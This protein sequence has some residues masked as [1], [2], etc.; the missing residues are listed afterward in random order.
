MNLKRIITL[1][2]GLTVFLSLAAE[3]NFQNKQE[4]LE[5]EFTADK[6]NSQYLNTT[7]AYPAA[8]IK[9]EITDFSAGK[10]V[11]QGDLELQLEK[12]TTS[13]VFREL[14]AHKI[15]LNLE[16]LDLDY[17]KLKISASKQAELP[18]TI[19]PAFQPLY[20]KVVENYQ[21]SYLR[22]LPSAFPKM[23]IITYDFLTEYLE[24]F[25]AWKEAKGIEVQVATIEEIGSSTENI[26]SFL[27][28]QYADWQPDYVILTGD[29][30]DAYQIPSYYITFLGETDVTDLPYCLLQGEDYW[31][32]ML[33]GR[34]S[35]DSPMELMTI[36][37]KILSYEKNP[38]TEE[39]WLESALLIA[40]NYSN[41]PPTPTTPVKVTKWLRDKM[42]DYGYQNI[43]E[44][45]YPGTYPGTDEIIASIDAGVG[46]V[47]YRG[48]GD[49]NGWHYP[50][51][52]R[53]NIEELNNGE[54][55]PV[56]TSIVCNTGDFA[57]SVDPCFGEL[58]L[59]TGWPTLTKGAVA[60][61][62]PSDL[63][64]STKYNNAVFAGF[65]HGLLTENIHGFASAVQ[66]GKI[67]LF[68]NYPHHQGQGDYVEFYFHVYNM[69][70]DP[71]LQMWTKTPET[72]NA[73][74]PSQIN[75]G[76]N[77]L[78]IDLPDL[79]GAIVTAMKDG[80]II[81]KEIVENGQAV[82]FFQLEITGDMQITIT[83]ANYL[84]LIENIAVISNNQDL[85][86]SSY[87]LT[88]EFVPGE[89]L[90][91]EVEVTNYGTE[92]T[93]NTS[94][95]LATT[96][97]QVEVLQ[98]SAEIP[99]LTAG[100]SASLTYSFTAAGQIGNAQAIHFNVKNGNDIIGKLEI[101][102]SNFNFIVTEHTIDDANGILEPGEQA[103]INLLLKNVGNLTAT[104]ISAELTSECSALEV[105]SAT[106][107]IGNVG[108]G[109]TTDATFNVAVAADCYVG[110]NARLK[111][112]FNSS[113]GQSDVAIYDFEI[114]DVDNTAPTGPDSFGY[115]AYDSYDVSYAEA[116][117]YQWE[118]IDPAEGG[119]G[120]VMEMGDD[121]SESIALPFEF[122][123]YSE[124]SDSI[125]ICSNG[126]I[127]MQTTWETNFRNWNIPAAIG[128]NSMVAAFW[129]DLIGANEEDMRVVYYYDPTENKFIIEWNNCVNNFDDVSPEK[130][131]IVLYDPQHYETVDGN[132]EIQFNYH[133]VS[134]PD[135]NNNYATIGIENPMQ[136]DGVKY[137][138]SSLFPASATPLE[139]G[140]A[141]KFTTDNPDSY[142]ANEPDA[143]PNLVQLH[144]NYP[145]PFNP[146]T[147]IEFSIPNSQNVN[148][149]IYNAKGQLVKT[150]LQKEIEAGHH[151]VVWYG[152]DK[153]N[154]PVSSG[155]YF[156]K[157]K[158]QNNE[159]LRKCLLIK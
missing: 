74:L 23:L 45:Y 83:K 142:T 92:T 28:E 149:A 76:A 101:I 59:R 139:A 99:A 135:A 156:Y 153:Q 148:L 60:F 82:L 159:F 98:N 24:D 81:N 118:E 62:G 39:D 154:E 150:L 61:V 93:A 122:T 107:Q 79:D 140:L 48:W 54:L 113:A 117:Q 131:Q 44:Y 143:I 103:E 68:N 102:S 129:D 124:V 8:E 46:F 22:N 15:E 49:A 40:G 70:A 37:S 41:S 84:P 63:H 145:N 5:L 108:V 31:P 136:T 106:S 96:H 119:S 95:T 75:L 104:D 152:K 64:T 3:V 97:P 126:W 67:E 27:A 17:L 91:L 146:Q 114:G 38:N 123:Y 94:L 144:Q 116:P 30:D 57:N 4:Y 1:I 47:T 43:D 155:I 80:E 69:L 147:T 110:R 26:K 65:Y 2:L 56:V 33:L 125:T 21:S 134:N 52:K 85:G 112:Y 111:L 42:Y 53:E 78:E 6:Q 10:E 66:R 12:N 19:S 77:Y 29:V 55:L 157:L 71:S 51:F 137:S 58:F 36:M 35:I 11:L 133:T 141:V 86:V 72:I 130:F 100:E 109:S 88:E 16:N 151:Q 73:T 34:I 89:E 32:E 128:P 132:G 105:T 20:S 87:Q 121:V 13:F 50:H 25:I 7:F 18:T 120:T 138:F 158:T 90:N 14:F 9:V 115:Y 127:S